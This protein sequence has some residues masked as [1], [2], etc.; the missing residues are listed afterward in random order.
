M[1]PM[2]IVSATALALTSL[3]VSGRSS[4]TNTPP[5]QLC[6]N[7]CGDMSASKSDHVATPAQA[8]AHAVHPRTS[9]ASQRI[10]L[11]QTAW[12]VVASADTPPDS[13]RRR[14]GLAEVTVTAQKY[15][16]PAFNVPISLAVISGA[17]LQSMG[18]NSLEQLQFAVP[19]LTVQ[20][21]DVERR[22]IIDGVSNI[23]GLG[24]VVGEYIDAADATSS[25]SMFGYNSLDIRTYDLSRVE[26]L[27]GPQ[28]TLYGEGAVGG[29][30]HLVTNEPILDQAEF[31]I[32]SESLFTKGGQPSEHLF[33]TINMPVINGTLGLRI[34]GEF[35]HDGGWID[36]PSA[37]QT[38]VNQDNLADLR[39]EA[40]WKASPKLEATVLEIIHRKS[41]VTGQGEDSAG[42]LVQA[43]NMAT[44][45]SGRD[46]Y[47]LS[48]LTLKYDLARLGDLVSATSYYDDDSVSLLTGIT[49]LFGP[50]PAPK[51]NAVSYPNKYEYEGLTQELRLTQAA[52]GPWT[53]TI[54]GQFK[55]VRTNNV[56]GD[57]LGQELSGGGYKFLAS[58]TP[59]AGGLTLQ[60]LLNAPGLTY[61]P[62]G[63]YDS[64]NSSAEFAD[65]SYR[66]MDRVTVGAGVRHFKDER[67]TVGMSAPFQ[68]GSFKSTDPRLYVLYRTSRYFNLYANAAKGFRSGGFNSYGQPPFGPES[69]WH[70][71]VG[72]K[73]REIGGFS[74]T[75]DVNYSNYSDYQTQGVLFIDGTIATATVN[76]GKVHIKGTEAS[77]TWSP[78]ETWTV[79]LAG[80]YVDARFVS[81]P[82]E[83]ATHN[84]GDPVDEVPRYQ[85]DGSV[86]RD[87][88]IA[89]RTA[90]VRSDYM[91]RS[92]QY[93]RNRSIGPWYYASSAN[94]YLLNLEAGIQW[95]EGL[96]M[97]VMGRNLLNDRGAMDPF[98][99]ENGPVRPRPAT[100]GFY[101]DARFD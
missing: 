13:P 34:A 47:N 53:W 74:A 55:R 76:G 22:I 60:G 81:V 33:P 75:A 36:L 25:P 29:A 67:S 10:R 41:F 14:S 96:S 43:F 73:T 61:F 46:H 78:D 54:G 42:D 63:E 7:T 90:F 17:N 38:D 37:S 31:G 64:S 18:D 45:P 28:G 11:S 50:P 5:S 24:G 4:A 32:R 59:V 23:F 48:A 35:D 56:A 6:Q 30:I 87:F 100:V 72:I 95:S 94:L 84:V 68:E 98:V 8:R 89:G 57:I 77:L 15:N 39:I 70:F 97:G 16:Q 44:A 79:T 9:P 69:L 93:Y 26:V 52:L 82:P 86:E 88:R 66:V 71:E 62:F 83:S 58:Q 19:G 3:S 65:L 101:F 80:N 85:L 12:T 2:L 91:Q 92:K 49:N 27:R 51:L 1:R 40:L 21:N 99:N 20:A